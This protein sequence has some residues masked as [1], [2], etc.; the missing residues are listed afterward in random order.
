MSAIATAVE[1]VD[2]PHRAS[3]AAGIGVVA[4]RTRLRPEVDTI[5]VAVEALVLTKIAIATRREAHLA[6]K[7]VAI[8]AERKAVHTMRLQGVVEKVA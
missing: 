8:H 7:I 4:A 3:E 1:A 6:T 5:L 2:I